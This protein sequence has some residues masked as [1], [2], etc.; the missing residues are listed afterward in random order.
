M[1]KHS[2]VGGFRLFI[3][4]KGNELYSKRLVK[5][6]QHG[7]QEVPRWMITVSYL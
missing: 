1:R 5:S 3:F 2:K 4:G 6:W 7:M